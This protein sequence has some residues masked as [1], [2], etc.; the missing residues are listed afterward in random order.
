M[1]QGDG[2]VN[3]KDSHLYFSREKEKKK[4]NEEQSPLSISLSLSLSFSSPFFRARHARE[5]SG[6]I[7]RYPRIFYPRARH[8]TTWQF[9]P[10]LS[11]GSQRRSGAFRFL[12]RRA[13]LRGALRSAGDWLSLSGRRD[14]DAT[15]APPHPFSSDPLD[16]PTPTRIYT[17]PSLAC[18]LYPRLPTNSLPLPLPPL[19]LCLSWTC[20]WAESNT[21]LVT[22]CHPPFRRMPFDIFLGGSCTRAERMME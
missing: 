2:R 9:L 8:V 4:K 7:I 14:A 10:T 11:R 21:R 20:T 5:T 13:R 18:A 17:P 22:G 1:A 15:F 3:W 12:G 16:T 19:C 6:R